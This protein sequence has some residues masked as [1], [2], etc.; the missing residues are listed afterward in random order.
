V[1]PSRQHHGLHGRQHDVGEW[2]G[3]QTRPNS[4]RFSWERDPVRPSGPTAAASPAAI[5]A[6]PPSGA[7]GQRDPDAGVVPLDLTTC[8]DSHPIKGDW[9]SPDDE[10]WLYHAPQS[11]S[12]AAMPPDRCFATEADAQAAGYRASE[13]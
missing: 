1:A 6:T 4:E 13:D 2:T 11:R 9:G 12:Y 10:D 3:L 5:R 7:A 8:P